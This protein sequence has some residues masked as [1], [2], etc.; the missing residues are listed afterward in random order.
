ML[1]TTDKLSLGVIKIDSLKGGGLSRMNAVYENPR[2]PRA[3]KNITVPDIHAYHSQESQQPG[4]ISNIKN[5]VAL[6]KSRSTKLSSTP[7][8]AMNL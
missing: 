7:N 4:T 8:S 1:E 6:L 5:T 3:E 2:L